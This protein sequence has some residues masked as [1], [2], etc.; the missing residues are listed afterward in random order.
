MCVVL[1]IF[2]MSNCTPTVGDTRSS[3]ESLKKE[4]NKCIQVLSCK[5]KN[6]GREHCMFLLSTMTDEKGEICCSLS[7]GLLLQQ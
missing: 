4:L 1:A 7:A 3:D 5:D 6:M 2:L